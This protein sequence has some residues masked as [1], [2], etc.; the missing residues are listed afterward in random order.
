MSIE[1]TSKI[2]DTSFLPLQVKAFGAHLYTN[3][4]KNLFNMLITFHA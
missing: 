1:D 3:E 4:I 2:P